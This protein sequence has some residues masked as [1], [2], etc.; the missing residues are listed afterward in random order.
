MTVRMTGSLK[1]VYGRVMRWPIM[2]YVWTVMPLLATVPAGCVLASPPQPPPP[3]HHPPT[4]VP[5]PLD[6]LHSP[7]LE[8]YPSVTPSMVEAASSSSSTS[9]R[10]PHHHSRGDRTRSRSFASG[11]HNHGRLWTTRRHWKIRNLSKWSANLQALDHH[12]GRG[13]TDRREEDRGVLDLGETWPMWGQWQVTGEDG[14]TQ[15]V[16]STALTQPL[17][18]LSSTP[19]TT[20]TQPPHPPPRHTTLRRGKHGSKQVGAR[21]PTPLTAAL[22]P[23]GLPPTSP[24]TLPP[25]TPLAEDPAVLQAPQDLLYNNV[26]DR[27]SRW[28]ALDRI[29]RMLTAGVDGECD[30]GD[31]RMG[32]CML[33]AQCR[34]SG[35]TPTSSCA[36]SYAICC[37]AYH[38]NCGS[39]VSSNRT[40][41]VSPAA[42][43]SD[44]TTSG[45][46]CTIRIKKISSSICYIRLDLIKFKLKS[47][48]D[49]N[50]MRDH[51]VVS[52]QNINAF[53][54]KL[55]GNNSGQHLYIDADTVSGPVELS[56]TTVGEGL[57]RLWEIEI[58][59]IECSSTHRPPANCL[60]YHIGTQGTFSSFN[61]DPEENAQYLNNLNYV[62]CIRK[63]A[64]FCS[65]VYQNP[66]SNNTSFEIANLQASPSLVTSAVPA[67][68]AG[69]G[70][71]QCP[72]DY[73]I[74]AGTRLC[75]DRLNDGSSN[76]QPTN[77]GPV[78]DSTNGPFI[79]QFT[80]DDQYTGHG[81]LLSFQQHPC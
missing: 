4:T 2:R 78:I 38:S 65:I 79:V 19:S 27:Q 18:L 81:F 62:I 52:G 16:P 35:G 13:W 32:M 77:N 71:I 76:P 29:L 72:N 73:L 25:P 7:L 30:A 45:G 56:I 10:R 66:S 23:T 5:A 34:R 75:G 59:Q 49:G 20:L 39:E 12:S 26:Y 11:R 64:G 6:T 63:E 55:C 15:V 36:S 58:S 51:L 43:K 69:V 9:H 47:P 61:Y 53:M 48:V 8:L 50:C 74:M 1:P 41:W 28:L 21:P 22:P 24:S 67:G 80:S 70:I 42:G 17:Q 37:V 44:V 14:M 57:E 46:T 54:P 60:Q 40:Y 31:G 68:E 33:E 3:H